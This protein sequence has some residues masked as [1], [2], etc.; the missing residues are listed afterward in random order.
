M[1]TIKSAKCRLFSQPLDTMIDDVGQAHLPIPPHFST[2][3]LRVASVDDVKLLSS[4]LNIKEAII[5]I[6]ST[7]F[8][9]PSGGWWQWRR[10]NARTASSSS[11]SSS[12]TGCRRRRHLTLIDDAFNQRHASYA[13]AHLLLRF[14]M[15]KPDMPKGDFG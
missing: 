14:M 3:L 2:F 7:I 12:T 5:I 6:A 15:G 4:I 9:P 13:S 10:H 1:L 11:S 8:L